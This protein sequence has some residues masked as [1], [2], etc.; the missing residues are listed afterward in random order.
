MEV[1]SFRYDNTPPNRESKDKTQ[2]CDTII[3]QSLFSIPHYTDNIL[4]HISY[5]LLVNFLTAFFHFPAL[6]ST[7]EQEKW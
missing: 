3:I 6:H 7:K 5:S 1:N 2:C 4:G